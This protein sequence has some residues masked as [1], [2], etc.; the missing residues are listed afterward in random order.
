[1]KHDTRI[2]CIAGLVLALCAALSVALSPT[3]ATEAGRAQLVYSDTAQ[4]GDPPEIALAIAMG[5][6]RGLFVN[7]LWIRA[8]DLKEEGRFYESIELARAITRL[9]PRFPRVW[10]FHAW[11]L[12]Y[13]ISVSTDTAA[14]RW[15]WVRAGIDLLRQEGI[16]KNPSDMQLQRELAWIFVHKVQGISDD[17]NRY[18]KREMAREWTAI[19]GPNPPRPRPDDPD[20]VDLLAEMQSE[21]K[22]GDPPIDRRALL[23]EAMVRRRLFVLSQIDS[24]PDALDE[25]TIRRFLESVNRNP[26]EPVTD[27]QARE[28]T[29][30]LAEMV[31]RLD[32]E[33]GLQL[34]VNLLTTFELR[35]ALALSWA[36]PEFGLEL[37]DSVRNKAFDEMIQ[38]P[39]YERAWPVL[40]THVRKMVITREKN[41]EISRMKRYTRKYGPLD[42]RHPASHAV[43]WATRGV[44]TGLARVNTADFDQANTDRIIVQA[45]QELFRWGD[46]YYDILNDTFVAMVDLDFTDSY[47]DTLKELEERATKFDDIARGHR[48]YGVGYRNYLI[49]VVRVYYR[50]GDFATAQRY[51]DQFKTW[52]GHNL[53]QES[54][55]RG[56]S[57]MTLEEFAH[58]DIEEQIEVPQYAVT[59]VT[60]AL[61]DAYL[62]GL[63]S[64]DAEVFQG[65]LQY[66]ADVHARYMKAQN[67]NTMAD[68]EN[69]MLQMPPRFVDVASAVLVNTLV[70]GLVGREEAAL[71]WRRCPLGLQQATFDGLS[72]ALNGA[73]PLEEF[74]RWF[75]EPEGMA[76]YRI[77]REKLEQQQDDVEG[78]KEN[79]SVE[80]Q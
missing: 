43:Y 65:Q 68:R 62:R 5:A 36:Q 30:T 53:S 67:R 46:I 28:L 78:R 48:L 61:R 72:A 41:M 59:E 3:I 77:D 11:N 18:Y 20:V 33:A 37:A 42:W 55:F 25:R 54:L 2:Q 45:L 71:I 56:L 58:Y 22:P 17:A 29:D 8:E 26:A 39:R 51:F 70:T 40:L 7:I 63:L 44:E 79:L 13:N 75:P 60:A 69:R 49:D 4:E 34:D 16:P 24:A 76:Q 1:M 80:E 21:A 50:M 74:R 9:Q 73:M 19:M 35:R 14:E 38:E 52:E 23:R 32:R 15:R 64:G 6:F 31:E 47:G 57:S 27:E 66:A 10:G 12:A